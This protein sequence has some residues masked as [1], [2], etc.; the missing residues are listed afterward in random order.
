MSDVLD[1]PAADAPGPTGPILRALR[2]GGL[3]VLPTETTYAVAASGLNP[4]STARLARMATDRPLSIA[5]PEPDA[6]VDWLPAIGALGRRLA[7]RCWPGPVTLRGSADGGLASRLPAEVGALLAPDGVVGV[8]SV[9]HP[10]IWHAARELGQPILMADT[11]ATTAEELAGA[12]GDEFAL[13]VSGGPSRYPE[14]PTVVRLDGESW[15]VERTGAIPEDEL[16]RLSAC[17]V[18][19]VCTGNTC[20]S[21]LAEALCKRQ[22]ADRLGCTAADLPGRGFWVLS[23]GVAAARGDPAATEAV[24]IAQQY[25]ADLSTHVSRPATAD[26]IAQADHVIAMTRGHL[27]AVRDR[28]PTPPESCE[29]LCGDEGDL[30]DPIGGDEGVYRECAATI[31]RH[32]ARLLAEWPLPVGGAAEGV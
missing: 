16:S 7:R 18:V 25:G 21:P 30:P 1:W 9:G 28:F 14:P 3:V 22:L 17:L 10:A 11:Q 13:V 2:H 8:R 29:L 4:A 32:L 24:R 6:A 12:G 5:L 19:F 27:M 23:A 26:L 31:S 15:T 20:R